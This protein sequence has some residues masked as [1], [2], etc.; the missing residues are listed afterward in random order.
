MADCKNNK[1]RA[2]IVYD[3]RKRFIVT[4]RSTQS[5]DGAASPHSA[6]THFFRA[7]GK[8]VSLQKKH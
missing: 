6:E 8:S 5:P 1:N 3:I 7:I 2:M 4:L